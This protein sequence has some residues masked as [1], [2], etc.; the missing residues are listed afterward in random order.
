MRHEHALATLLAKEAKADVLSAPLTGTSVQYV[1]ELGSTMTIS[2]NA[3]G[4][5]TGT[6]TSLVSGGS[7]TVSGPLSGWYQGYVLAW[8]VQWPSN[9]PSITSWVGAFVQNASGSY[10]LDTMWLLVSQSA[11]PGNASEFWSAVNTGS[12]LFQPQ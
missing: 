2:F 9:P 10:N 8:S 5:V 1:N 6:Y 12:D 7:G 11:N 3:D 4:T